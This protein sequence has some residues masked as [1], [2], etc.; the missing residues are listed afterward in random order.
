MGLYMLRI[1]LAGLLGL[2]I[3]STITYEEKIPS[4]RMFSI[5]CMGSALVTVTGIGVYQTLTISWTG[6]PARLPAQIISALGFLGTGFIWIQEDRT[7]SGI[8]GA[9][10]MW[11]TAILGMLIGMGLNQASILGL[12]FFIIVYWLSH[13]VTAH[14][15]KRNLS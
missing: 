12:F 7:V 8:S 2:L 13:M 4:A 3:G 10:A 14:Y 5:I 1:L 6:D 15:K 11:I 9:A